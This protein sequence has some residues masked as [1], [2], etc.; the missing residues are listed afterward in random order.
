MLRYLPEHLINQIAAGEVVERPAAVIKEL[1]E[2]SIDAGASK[3]SIAVNDG[4]QTLISVVDDGCGMAAEELPLSV[5]RH[6][7]SK[8]PGDDLSEVRC[9]GFRGEALPAIGAVSHLSLTSRADGANV[10]SCLKVDGG[11]LHEVGPAALEG[12]TSVEVR[13]IFYAT[14]ARL[15][16]M[17]SPRAEVMATVDM[18]NQLSMA[19]PD[20]TVV[21]HVDGRQ[22]LFYSSLGATETELRLNRLKDVMGKEF[23]ENAIR[24]ESSRN[25]M[26]I[27]GYASLPT[28]NKGNA[29]SQFFFVNGRPV[30]DKLIFGALRASY[31]GLLARDRHPSVVLFLSLEA[32]E[33]DVNVHPS[34]SEVRFREPGEV[35][36]LLIGALRHA[37]D[38]EEVRS[39]TAISSSALGSMRPATLPSLGALEPIAGVERGGQPP[40]SGVGNRVIQP[41][42]KPAPEYEE[43]DVKEQ[44]NFPL[45]AA[46]GQLHDTY[47]VAQTIDGF[48]IVDQHAAHERLVYEHMKADLDARGVASQLLL[49][50]EV[51]ELDPERASQLCSRASQLGELGLVLEAFG[52]GAVLVRETPAILG[53]TDANGLVKQLSESLEHF[54]DTVSLRTKLEEVCSTMACHGSV[55]AGRR[56]NVPEMNSLLRQMESTPRSGQCNHG[57]PTYID[58]R[59]A[60]IERLF[61][62]R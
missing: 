15:K 13:D 41:S 52:E 30:R 35:R 11:V 53:E 55:R 3:I 23:M 10:A 12:G 29:R 9:L 47:I 38:S 54:L 24:I 34:K 17:K 37:L 4:G 26:G 62:R 21:L 46:L 22:R 5:T 14:P 56:L 31:Q 1:V 51:V 60:D 44:E 36:G 33:V 16:F 61:G 58:L 50:P 8:L 32:S 7:T 49:I 25:H 2:N 27:T 20:I 28:F 57:R 19:R 48:V 45:G 39:S 18:I 43:S 6:V 42:S 59:L 40:A